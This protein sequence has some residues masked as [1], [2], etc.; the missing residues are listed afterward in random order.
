LR[1][2][3]RYRSAPLCRCRFA[4]KIRCERPER[5]WCCLRFPIRQWCC[6]SCRPF[7]S[8]CS[9]P[10]SWMTPPFPQR[11]FQPYRHPTIAR[12]RPQLRA[13]CPLLTLTLFASSYSPLQYVAATAAKR[14][15]VGRRT[16]VAISKPG[17]GD[18]RRRWVRARCTITASESRCRHSPSPPDS[19]DGAYALRPLKPL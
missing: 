14:P 16:C 4:P 11:R 12:K 18:E 9:A 3:H 2:L 8:C 13:S 6:L 1:R 19:R 15:G 5:R 10:L 17:Y 7:Q